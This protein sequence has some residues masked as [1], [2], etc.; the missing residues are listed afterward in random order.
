MRKTTLYEELVQDARVEARAKG[1]LDGK[2]EARSQDC[3]RILKA[4]LGTVPKDIRSQVTCES[5]LK[6]LDKLLDLALTADS[7]AESPAMHERDLYPT[8]A[9]SASRRRPTVRRLS[10]APCVA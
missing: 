4:R 7:P 6:R 8:E 1:R 5:S 3:L 9:R 2:V 10:A